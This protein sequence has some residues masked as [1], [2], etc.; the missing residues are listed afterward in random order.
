MKKLFLDIETAP[1][2]ALT[3][4]LFKQN[5]SL[6][7]IVDSGYTLCWAAKW[8]DEKEVMFSST[9]GDGRVI[10]LQRIH[11]LLTEADAVVHYNGRNFDMP[12][13]NKEF[14]KLGMLPPAPYQQIDLLQTVRRNFRLTSNKLDYVASFLGIGSKLP[15]KG[16]KLWV[17]C[18]NGDAKDWKMM[19][20][21][22]KQDVILLPKVYKKLLPWIKD[23]PNHALYSDLRD[24]KGK[25]VTQCPNC[26]GTH[27]H[28]VGMEHLATQSYQRYRCGDCG[29]PLRGRT[30]ALTLTKR[31]SIITQS[32]L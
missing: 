1:N 16:M 11:E 19:E 9:H 26:G 2:H 22:N 20:R 31:K 28:R 17:G 27:I 10:M 23:H 14:L 29:T 18:M 15:H 25:P 6:D 5:I 4:G 13:L 12:I 8:E 3:W 32:K 24:N 30:T 21:Y 7:Q